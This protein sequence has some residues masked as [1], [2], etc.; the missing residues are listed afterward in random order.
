MNW[1]GTVL[2]AAIAVFGTLTATWMTHAYA[3]RRDAR[4]SQREQVQHRADDLRSAARRLSDLLLAENIAHERLSHESR[5]RDDDFNEHYEAHLWE[6][7]LFSL[8][9][10]VAMLPDE[11]ARQRLEILM[12]DLA[13]SEVF[14]KFQGQAW[15]L[16]SG[17][18]LR[19]ASA[20]ANSCARGQ[21]PDDDTTEQYWELK[22]VHEAVSAASLAQAKA[23]HPSTF[24]KQRVA[25]TR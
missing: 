7:S 2:T 22:E 9:Q 17:V 19:V 24:M 14:P 8:R 11:V 6:G 3:N 25:D 1:L 12:R 23:L 16:T 13:D 21:E 15:S 20:I 18:I 10:A 5:G 4:A